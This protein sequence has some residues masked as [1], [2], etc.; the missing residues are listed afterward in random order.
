MNFFLEIFTVFYS[1]IPE[2]TQHFTYLFQGLHGK[3]ALVPWM[4]TSL[5]M[6]FVA[7]ALLIYPPTRQNESL[8]P[9]ACV[10]VFIS[11]WIDKG[12]GMIS[13]GFVPSPLEHVTEYMPT[14]PEL[15]ISLMVY[16]IGLLILTVLYKI[17]LAVK[18]STPP[19]GAAH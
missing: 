5:G 3:D 14:L 18:E 12:M 4:W 15:A 1:Q 19:N 6:A 11:T 17:T 8:L 13:G 7:I 16:A 10:L 9:L 2:H